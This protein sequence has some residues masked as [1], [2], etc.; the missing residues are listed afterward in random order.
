MR[1]MISVS[2]LTTNKALAILAALEQAEVLHETDVN[3]SLLEHSRS[4]TQS[5]QIGTTGDVSPDVSPADSASEPEQTEQPEPEQPEPEQLP[6]PKFDWSGYKPRPFV[7]IPLVGVA[8][9]WRLV[10]LHVAAHILGIKETTLYNLCKVGTVTSVQRHYRNRTF[11]FLTPEQVDILRHALN[12]QRR[13]DGRRFSRQFLNRVYLEWKK[14]Q[15]V[16]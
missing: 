6:S 13:L 14:Q 15:E 2:N 9:P 5:S 16:A 8:Q 10:S 11:H 12:E 3:V 1:M 4:D 7:A